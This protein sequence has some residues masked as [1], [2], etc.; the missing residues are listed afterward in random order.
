[1]GAQGKHD[2]SP[3]ANHDIPPA[4]WAAAAVGLMIVLTIL[5]FL[6]MKAVQDSESPPDISIKVVG[7]E[8]QQGKYLVRLQ[9]FNNGGSTA[10]QVAV[11]G[12]VEPQNSEIQ[13]SQLT[14]DYVPAH[15]KRGAGL[16]FTTDPMKARLEV[17]AVGYQ[18]P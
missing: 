7:I 17:R 2:G 10:A 9:V 6:L 12:T 8:A 13:R 15:S 3:R 14:L 16:F 18:T 1:M 5:G 4:E 11:E